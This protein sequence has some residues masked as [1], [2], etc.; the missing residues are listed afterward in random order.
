MK[1]MKSKIPLTSLSHTKIKYFSSLNSKKIREKEGLFLI[2]GKKMVQEAIRENI[3]LKAILTIENEILD[4][5]KSQENLEIYLCKKEDIKKISCLEN[6]EGIIAVA[7]IFKN[8]SFPSNI[9]NHKYFV[10]DHIQDP[11][12]LG[13]ILRV[14]DA[15]GIQGVILHQCVDIYNPKVLRASMGAIFRVPCYYTSIEKLISYYPNQFAKADMNGSPIN[16]EN[17]DVYQFIVLGNEAN[18]LVSQWNQ[19]INKSI[20]IPQIGNAESLNVG[21]ASGI[22]AW[23]W[24]KNQIKIL[25]SNF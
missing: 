11:G 23:E 6:P 10:L 4:E 13:T 21:V 17:L 5:L 19:I 3:K 2:E 12:N 22:L 8:H 7:S 9:K 15:F 25:H 18:G 16:L 1:K 20:T 24:T 14:C